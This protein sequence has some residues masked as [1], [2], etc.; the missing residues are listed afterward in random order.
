MFKYVVAAL[1][2]GAEAQSRFRGRRRRNRRFSTDQTLY[3]APTT[4]AAGSTEYAR[5]VYVPR[6]AYGTF[7]SAA[8]KEAVKINE[9]VRGVIIAESIDT[10]ANTAATGSDV[11]TYFSGLGHPTVTTYQAGIQEA[12]NLKL[13]KCTWDVISTIQA[14][15]ALA[16]VPVVASTNAAYSTRAGIMYREDGTA[17]LKITAATMDIKTN[18]DDAA[19]TAGNGRRSFRGSLWRKTGSPSMAVVAAGTT[20]SS[21][22]Y[23]IEVTGQDLASAQTERIGCGVFR[24]YNEESAKKRIEDIFLPLGDYAAASATNTSGILEEMQN[25]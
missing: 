8:H 21:V 22:N 18:A 19:A 25:N 5:A 6:K 2:A 7:T 12:A 23:V 20:A 11:Y 16:A 9:G 17:H 3:V 15:A 24:P 10:T 14:N 4:I 1:A 13:W